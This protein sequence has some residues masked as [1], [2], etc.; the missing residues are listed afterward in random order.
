MEEVQVEMEAPAPASAPAPAPA[1]APVETAKPDTDPMRKAAITLYLIVQWIFISSALILY[2]KYI[3]STLDF[4]YPLTLVLMH[5]AFVTCATNVWRALSWA[6]IPVVSLNDVMKHFVPVAIFFGGS[7]AFSN[8]AYLFLSVAFIQIMKASTPVWVLAF[9]IPFGLQRLDRNLCVWI[10]IIVGGVSTASVAQVDAD[11]VGVVFQLLALGCESMRLVLTNAVLAARGLKLQP[12][13]ALYYMAP[14][15]A[16]VLVVPWLS[17]EARGVFA[18]GGAALRRVGALVLVSNASVAFLLNLATV[19]LIKHTSALT[20]NVSGVVKDFLLILFSALVNKA[21]VT[22]IQYVGYSVAAV[23]VLG[24]TELK[25]RH[26]TRKVGV[27]VGVGVRRFVKLS[28]ETP[29]ASPPEPTRQQQQQARKAWLVGGAAVIASMIFG[30]A[31]HPASSWL[32]DAFAAADPP[33]LAPA[34]PPPTPPTPPPPEWPVGM[35]RHPPAPPAPPSRPPSPPIFSVCTITGTN[36]V[37]GMVATNEMYYAGIERFAADAVN[38]GAPCV[39][40]SVRHGV[41]VYSVQPLVHRLELPLAAHWIPESRFCSARSSGWRHAGVLKTQLLVHI[42]RGQ[43]DCFLVDTDWRSTNGFY[44][45]LN[46]LQMSDID[47]AAPPDGENNGGRLINLGLLWMRY[48]PAM[49]RVA[50][51]VANRTYGAWDQLIFNQEVQPVGELICCASWHL[52]QGAHHRDS[53]HSALG[54][55]QKHASSSQEQCTD[56]RAQYPIALPPPPGTNDGVFPQW[57]E[58]GYNIEARRLHSRC[59]G[60][61]RIRV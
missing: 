52:L 7:L 59:I 35:P 34:M 53:S 6:E 49:L 26:D 47:I 55:D 23:G 17:L 21:I 60:C 15:C 2:N 5:M 40:A 1:P 13:A 20:L 36:T 61:H 42:L 32:A 29:P 39:V 11:A 41:G 27:G 14:L 3:L 10:L 54:N 48:K 43:F 8:M 56:N 4:A 9:S 38:H 18:H 45:A 50:E 46:Q 57:H 44:N 22:P 19:T 12:I 25:R 37:I 51:R 16:L 24:Y 33:P 58:Q 31:I 30:F 28:D